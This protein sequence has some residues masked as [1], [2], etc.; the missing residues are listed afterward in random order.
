[1]LH[2]VRVQDAFAYVLFGVVIVGTIAAVF[3]FFWSGKAYDQIGKG[4][5]FIDEDSR[6]S[7]APIN[8]AERDDEIRQM[9][10]ARNA[11]REAAGLEQVDVEEE[12]ARLIRPSIDAELQAEI[13]EHVVARNARRIRRGQE[14]LDVDA[15][16]ERQIAELS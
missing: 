11:R 2:T 10:A 15:E 3:S 4:G 6:R 9:L 8:I 5:F 7:G 12:L 13:R 14:P 1:M 16:V